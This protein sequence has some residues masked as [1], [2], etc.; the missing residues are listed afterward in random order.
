ITRNWRGEVIDLNL[1]FGSEGITKR[2]QSNL[3]TAVKDIQDVMAGTK[4][5]P[6]SVLDN[7]VLQATKLI[8]NANTELQFPTSGGL[9]AVDP[10]NPNYLVSFTSRGIGVSEDG[11]ATFPEA[12]TGRGVNAS[13]ITTGAMLADRIAGGILTSLNDS[14]EFNLNTG[15]LDMQQAKFVLGSGA[16]IDFTWVGNRIQYRDTK[17]GVTRSSGFGVGKSVQDLPFAYSGTT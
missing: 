14:T 9:I 7:A 2:Y 17:D 12:I 10:D 13:A 1:T 5:I 4:K 3:Q 16:S 8:Q 6:Y 15:E 11:G